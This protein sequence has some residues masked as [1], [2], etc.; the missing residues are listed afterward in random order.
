ME[1]TDN[2]EQGVLM[3]REQL[4]DRDEEICRIINQK[5]GLTETEYDSLI[6]EKAE[7]EM[8]LFYD[9]GRRVAEIFE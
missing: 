4:L 8:M 6:K 7:I 1:P 3:T 2:Q 5:P 9:S